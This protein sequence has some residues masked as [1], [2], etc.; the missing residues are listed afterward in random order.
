MLQ[1]ALTYLSLLLAMSIITIL[2]YWSDKQRAQTGRR[3]MP[4]N[5]LH[6]LAVSGGWPGAWWAQQRLR[7]KTQKVGFLAVFW[8]LVAVHLAVVGAVAYLLL[9]HTPPG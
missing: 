4:E 2:V 1:A 5:V 3:R 7:H 6:L 8:V 9:A